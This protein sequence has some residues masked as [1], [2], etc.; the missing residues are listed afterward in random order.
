MQ[1]WKALEGVKRTGTGL[2][3]Y[4]TGYG[5]IT[6]KLSRALLP[7]CGGNLSLSSHSCLKS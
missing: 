1:V 2:M 3:P 4:P 7:S 6:R 5:G